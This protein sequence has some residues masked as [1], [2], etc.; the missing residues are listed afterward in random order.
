MIKKRHSFLT[1]ITICILSIVLLKWF[2]DFKK[3]C[4]K[5]LHLVH[6]NEQLLTRMLD[7]ENERAKEENLLS[8]QTGYKLPPIFITIKRGDTYTIKNNEVWVKNEKGEKQLTFDSEGNYKKSFLSLSPNQRY[9]AYF[10]DLSPNEEISNNDYY[11][12]NYTTIRLLDL[13]SGEINEV[14]RGSFKV[15]EYEWLSEREL[16]VSVGCGT[17]CSYLEI[18]DIK[19]LNKRQLMYGVGYTWS[20]NKRYVFAYQYTIQSGLI[21][22]DRFGNKL[23][24]LKRGY[25]KTKERFSTH[26]AIW[27]PDSAKLALIINKDGQPELE[28]LV[29]DA[30]N[31]FK[32]I[33]QKDLE[34][35]EFSELGW[36]D[37]ESV[38]YKVRGEIMEVN[39]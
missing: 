19:T 31:G 8:A 4:E 38:F 11:W 25:P 18:L 16:S 34:G 2:I 10:Q 32:I 37:E 39:I 23:F 28:L 30:E 15:G 14:Y 21:V 6:K 13:A 27:S 17:E 29:F 36:K 33:A 1:I 5:E 35:K 7:L 9:L 3:E 22:G 24:T 12:H 26:Q 20:P